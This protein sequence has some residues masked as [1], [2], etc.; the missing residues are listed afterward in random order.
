M[1]YSCL[2]LFLKNLSGNVYINGV[3]MCSSEM[4]MLVLFAL[5]INIKWLGRV[6]AMV[7]LF[8]IAILCYFI[9]IVIMSEGTV[10]TIS[11]LTVRSV[12]AGIYTIMSTYSSEVYEVNVSAK[13]ASVNWLSGQI[14]LIISPFLIEYLGADVAYVLGPLSV[15]CLFLS[16]CLPETLK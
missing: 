3:I 2:G 6:K 4:V 5:L 15:C 14:G 7:G 8:T 13:G 12:I 1:T 11:S 9:I 10:L 16:I